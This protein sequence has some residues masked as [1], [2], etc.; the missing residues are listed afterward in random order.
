M[1]GMHN[2]IAPELETIFVS[3]SPA[4]RH[5]AANLVRAIVTMELDPTAFVSPSVA[6]SLKAKVKKDRA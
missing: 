5:I 2:H 3:A 1:A 4:V 6:A